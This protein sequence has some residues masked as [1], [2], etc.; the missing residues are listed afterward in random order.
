[1]LCGRTVCVRPL[2]NTV[3][4]SARRS[5]AREIDPLSGHALD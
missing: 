5:R 4:V 2:N 1:L 3:N